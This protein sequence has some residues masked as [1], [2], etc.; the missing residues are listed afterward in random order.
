MQFVNSLQVLLS[1]I[2]KNDNFYEKMTL[3]EEQLAKLEDIWFEILDDEILVFNKNYFDK[4]NISFADYMKE[5][6][7]LKQFFIENGFFTVENYKNFFKMKKLTNSETKEDL[8]K[9][10]AEVPE[11]DEKLLQVND[12]IKKFSK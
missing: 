9:Y 12:F 8:E 2:E 3:L 5:G 4:E 10:I 6:A 7:F 1:L 11:N